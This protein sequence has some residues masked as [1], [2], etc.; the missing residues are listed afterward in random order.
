M[1]TTLPRHVRYRRFVVLTH[2]ASLSFVGP[3]TIPDCHLGERTDT[4]YGMYGFSCQCK[5]IVCV[6]MYVMGH[7]ALYITKPWTCTGTVV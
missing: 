6:C 2:R 4:Q 7:E 5:I 3:T 1:E